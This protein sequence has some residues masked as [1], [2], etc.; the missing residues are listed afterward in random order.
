MRSQNYTSNMC[1]Y[2]AN[3]SPVLM[4]F[5]DDRL[6][7]FSLD[8][9]FSLYAELY[10]E[11]IIHCVLRRNCGL[12]AFFHRESSLKT[13]PNPFRK[14]RTVLFSQRL[15]LKRKCITK[16]ISLIQ[17][18]KSSWLWI[19]AFR[20]SI[21]GAAFTWRFCVILS[22]FL[23]PGHQ[24]LEYDSLFK[25]ISSTEAN[26][27]FVVLGGDTFVPIRTC[28]CL[29][30]FEKD[31]VVFPYWLWINQVHHEWANVS[32]LLVRALASGHRA[33]LESKELLKSSNFSLVV[34]R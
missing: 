13:N 28:M 4:D 29:A 34:F 14:P 15:V 10:L 24:A 12:V 16:G 22:Y 32:P 23:H 7:E 2:A 26:V 20:L 8:P 31:V 9:G 19:F 30:N 3:I 27:I 17:S 6:R 25:L 1:H 18:S 21:F 11:F 33:H 5:R